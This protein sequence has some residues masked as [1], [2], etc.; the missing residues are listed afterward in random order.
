MLSKLQLVKKQ[1]RCG[2]GIAKRRCQQDNNHLGL[3]VHHLAGCWLVWHDGD[4][5]PGILWLR[6]GWSR[7]TKWRRGPRSE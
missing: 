1:E 5:V 6:K 2:A 3:H 4:L 7:W